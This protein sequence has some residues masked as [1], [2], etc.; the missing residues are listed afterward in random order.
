[1]KCLFNTE[2]SLEPFTFHDHMLF[3][4]VFANSI[5]FVQCGK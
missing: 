3:L 4:I 1:M 5:A 2:R